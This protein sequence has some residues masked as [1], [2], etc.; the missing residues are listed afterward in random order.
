M[1]CP[2]DLNVELA[3]EHIYSEKKTDFDMNIIILSYF[4]KTRECFLSG[5]NISIQMFKSL[6]ILK[7][8]IGKM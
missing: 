7:K 6:K 2:S 1:I 4:S 8:D 5:T 3:F